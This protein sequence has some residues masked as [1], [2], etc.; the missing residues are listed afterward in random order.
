MS[1][2]WLSHIFFPQRWAA[3]N[4]FLHSNRAG[5]QLQWRPKEKRN[6]FSSV[7]ICGPPPGK[8]R[9]SFSPIVW[10]R[11]WVTAFKKTLKP[12]RKKKTLNLKG[13]IKVRSFEINSAFTLKILFQCVFHRPQKHINHPIACRVTPWPKKEKQHKPSFDVPVPRVRAAR[14]AG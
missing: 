5:L 8:Q 6:C 2:S 11:R 7:D 1:V 13:S 4:A 12:E 3:G 14:G 10:S 9:L